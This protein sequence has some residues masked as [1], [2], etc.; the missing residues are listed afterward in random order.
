VGAAVAGAVVAGAAVAGAAVAGA[1]VAGTGVVAVGPQEE[2]SSEVKMTRLTTEESMY[3]L[4]ISFS[5]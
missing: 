1:A 5:P 4:L 3:F 2:S